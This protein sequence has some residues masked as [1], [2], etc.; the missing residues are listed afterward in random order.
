MGEY[1]S[2]FLEIKNVLYSQNTSKAYNLLKQLLL[3]INND[4]VTSNDVRDKIYMSTTI[5][6]LLPVLNDLKNDNLS[7]NVIKMFDLDV[8]KFS[9]TSK[10]KEKEELEKPFIKKQ[11]DKTNVY[12]SFKKDESYEKHISKHEKANKKRNVLV[13]LTLN[14]YIGQEKA[15]EVLSIA[16]TAA[17]M[18]DSC[19][20]HMLICSPYGIGKTTLANIVANE[21]EMPFVTV[22]AVALKDVKSLMNFF[23]KIN[24]RC[25]IFIDEIHKLSKSIQTVLLTIITDYVVDY[26]NEAGDN[27]HIDL[28][29]FTIIGAT[30]QAGELLKPF[31]NRFTLLELTDYTEEEKRKMVKSK[32]VAL[33]YGVTEGA[34]TDIANRCRGI[35]R[36]IE[37][38][39]KGLT[40]LALTKSTDLINL[41]LCEEYFD[42]NDID[43]NG[44]T[45]NDLMILKIIV[46]SNKPLG[47]ITIESKSGIQKED[48]EYRYEPY[49][50]KLK[51]IEKTEKGRV[52]TQKGYEYI[53]PTAP[54]EDNDDNNKLSEENKLLEIDK[55]LNGSIN[56]ENKMITFI[57]ENDNN[58]N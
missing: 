23:E 35:P 15:K 4:F 27:I 49:L 34:I 39:V 37:T 26:I 21:M 57:P 8:S 13:P 14:D 42:I 6:K 10:D 54:S 53:Y 3:D 58:L 44:L 1:L 16:I 46:D 52:A 31:I 51:L 55:I 32:F 18:K 47:L 17:K 28:P 41:K 9:I 5:E 43:E 36:T 11:E 24:E 12:E 30:T 19:L 29:E 22:N 2:R 7:N 40:D 50:L 48:I 25:V 20:S 33:E 38:F 56:E 45:K